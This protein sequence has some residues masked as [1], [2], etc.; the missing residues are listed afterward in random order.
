VHAV[1]TLSYHPG[2]GFDVRV[3]VAIA[4]CACGSEPIKSSPKTSDYNHGAL[5]AA[6]DKFVAANRTAPA[7]GE[8]ARAVTALRPGM[9]RAVAEEAERKLLVLALAP[10][11]AYSNKPM[12]EQI[13]ALATIV[14]PFLLAPAIEADAILSVRDPHAAEYAPK[15]GEDSTAY[16]LRVCEGPLHADCKRIVPELQGA[17]VDAVAI[18]HG[19]ERVRNAV[20]D[21]LECEGDPGWRQAVTGWETLDRDAAE[22]VIDV[23]RRGDPGNWPIA[24]NASD[25]DP[26]LPEA[27]V[28]PRGD[29]VIDNHSYGPNQQRIAVLRELR[30]SSDLV[31][32]HFHPDISLA[33]ARAMLADAR[34]AGCARV[35]AIAREPVYPWRRRA[36][37]IADGSGLRVALRPSDSLQLLVHAVD[38][39]AGPGTIVRVD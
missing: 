38:E 7:F 1:R 8:L 26:T 11:Q 2:V 21:C 14:W 5:V 9:D 27:E 19:V 10:M 34:K 22:W 29:L 20:G 33:Q 25:D 39:V 16:L 3:V 23:E 12:R 35:A 18:R 6:V 30:G 32:L 13:D 31:A 37:W 28:S 24:G 4:A 15:P 17:I 36:Y